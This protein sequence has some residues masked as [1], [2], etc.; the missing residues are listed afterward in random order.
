MFVNSTTKISVLYTCSLDTSNA[1]YFGVVMS[2][3]SVQLYGEN[4]VAS[5]IRI[6]MFVM[7]KSTNRI[8]K[9]LLLT[10]NMKTIT[11]DRGDCNEWISKCVSD[12]GGGFVFIA[13]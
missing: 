3:V 7:E 1:M 8:M 10:L 11:E 13:G 2:D 6:N 9:F 12:W 4:L 5:E